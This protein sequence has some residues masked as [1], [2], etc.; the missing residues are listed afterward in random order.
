MLYLVLSYC[1]G[2]GNNK[3]KE[4]AQVKTQVSLH[5]HQ[6]ARDEGQLE[7]MELNMPGSMR[8]TKMFRFPF[9]YVHKRV[10]GPLH[11]LHPTLP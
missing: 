3:L 4:E 2:S 11:L 9:L 1:S 7:H 5:S 10:W 6:G 8:V